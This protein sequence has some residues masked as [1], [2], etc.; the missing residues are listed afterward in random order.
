MEALAMNELQ[1]V[2]DMAFSQRLAAFRK[3]RGLTQQ[4]LAEKVGVRVLQISRY[5]NGSSQPTLDVIRKMAM[6]LQVTSDEIIFDKHERG[7]EDDLKI[8]FEAVTQ[9]DTREKEVIK[10][11]IDG[12][13]IKHDA[14]R[15]LLAG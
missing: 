9:L 4:E 13:L 14:K 6:A 7:P 11:L 12:M 3:A 8:K 1:V 15:R 2:L 10:E 5:E